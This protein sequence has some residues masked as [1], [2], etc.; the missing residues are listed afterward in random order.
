MTT[1]FGD[2]FY[3]DKTRK[4]ACFLNA[5]HAT[6]EFVDRDVEWVLDEFFKIPDICEAVFRA[7][8][9]DTLVK[10]QRSLIYHECFILTPWQVLGGDESVDDFEIGEC[11]VYLELIGQAWT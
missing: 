11:S 2:V 7:S 6:T 9:F 3:W 5:Q 4:A 8:L 1:G 10:E